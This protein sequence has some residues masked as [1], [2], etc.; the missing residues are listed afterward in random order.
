MFLAHPKTCGDILTITRT[1]CSYIYAKSPLCVLLGSDWPFAHVKTALL[2]NTL[3][4]AFSNHF[5]TFFQYHVHFFKHL[6]FFTMDYTLKSKV[7]HNF[8]NRTLEEQNSAQICTTISTM[9]ASHIHTVIC[10]TL[11]TFV[12]QTQ[13][14]IKM[15][16]PC[17][18][19][20][21]TVK[22]P[23]L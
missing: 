6:Q 18:S 12:Y 13:K 3:L 11:N 4:T 10:K 19:K 17:N 7:L 1:C 14:Y 23:H 22:L 2:S 16:R 8:P 21:L 5:H 15:S 9:L 20:T